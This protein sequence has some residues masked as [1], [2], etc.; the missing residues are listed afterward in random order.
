[1]TQQQTADDD[2]AEIFTDEKNREIFAELVYDDGATFVFL[3]LN[4]EHHSYTDSVYSSLDYA[5]AHDG[6]QCD[7]AF[8]EGK[9]DS[10]IVPVDRNTLNKI[11]R[12]AVNLGY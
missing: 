11:L 7:E 10:H 12:W 4:N 3:E 2:T 5:L 8:V 9:P 1:M 6:L